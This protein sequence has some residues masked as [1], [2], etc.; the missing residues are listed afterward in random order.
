MVWI[1]RSSAIA[2][3]LDVW[4]VA[5][6]GTYSGRLGIYEPRGDRTTLAVGISQGGPPVYLDK[7]IGGFNSPLGV[8]AATRH[9]GGRT[10]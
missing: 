3:K 5:S 9:T 7:P 8:S 4:S 10:W 2:A 6:A 1:L